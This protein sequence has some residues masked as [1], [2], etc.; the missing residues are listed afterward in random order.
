MHSP[1]NTRLSRGRATSLL[2]PRGLRDSIGDSASRRYRIL[3]TLEQ[4]FFEREYAPIYLPPFERFANVAPAM[5][6]RQDTELV[7]FVD[8]ADDQVAVLPPDATPQVARLFA[9][10]A[11]QTE[12]TAPWNVFYRQNIVRLGNQRG[13]TRRQRLHVGCESIRKPNPDG[14]LELVQTVIAACEALGLGD[15][16]FEIGHVGPV[17]RLLS[18]VE[19]AGAD[20]SE[21]SELRTAL[22]A[23]DKT[24]VSESLL[25][26]PGG[27]Q[28]QQSAFALL[29]LHGSTDLPALET[30]MLSK[31]ELDVA[32]RCRAL[33]LASS[34]FSEV[35]YDF[36]DISTISYYTGMRFSVHL[37]GVGEPLGSGGRYDELIEKFG[38]RA[39]AIGFAF[40]VDNVD[41]AQIDRAQMKKVES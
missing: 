29:Q 7:R 39:E 34:A 11:Q 2:P 24:R 41:R 10:H 4:I 35:H 30:T 37:P 16:V 21:L 1:N 9:R 6:H 28:L 17:S 8:S 5:L 36:G 15:L 31:E 25:L 20:E 33:A 13:R 32:R 22:R 26:L 19:A 12:A 27:A 18:A 23:K 14:E 3:G 38:T 40:D